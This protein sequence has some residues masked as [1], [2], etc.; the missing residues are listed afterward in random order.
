MTKQSLTETRDRLADAFAKENSKLDSE[1][2]PYGWGFTAGFESATAIFKERER[3]LRDALN[4]RHRC[5][6]PVSSCVRKVL[7]REEW[8]LGCNCGLKEALAACS[9]IE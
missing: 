4:G 8:E 7:S 5:S 9:E 6:C 1:P 3:V 2:F